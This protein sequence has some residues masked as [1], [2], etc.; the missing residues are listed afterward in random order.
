MSQELSLIKR[1]VDAVED[2]GMI[3]YKEG[4]EIITAVKRAIGVTN[5]TDILKLVGEQIAHEHYGGELLGGIE[6]GLDI[7][8][9]KDISVKARPI[10][11]FSKAGNP[12]TAT[13]IKTS[14]FNFDLVAVVLFHPETSSFYQIVEFDTEYVKKHATYDA[15]DNIYTMSLNKKHYQAGRIVHEG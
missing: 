8:S 11:H 12:V 2:D 14:H 4:W 1:I 6:K 10:K 3:N 13:S 7:R 9:D 15:H 5:S